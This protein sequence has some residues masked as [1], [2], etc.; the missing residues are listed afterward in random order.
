MDTM[1][2]DAGPTPERLHKAGQFFTVAGRARSSRKVTMLDDALGK[3]WLRQII[4]AQ[5][6]SALRRYALHWV[7]GGLQGPLGSVDLNRIYAFDPSS[8]TGLARSEAQLDHK[9]TYYAAKQAIGFNP[10]FVAD[11]VA[12]FGRGLQ[13]T[14]MSMGFRSP[15]RARERAAEYLS[16]AGAGLSK[17]FETLRG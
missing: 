12:C 13:E 11:Q 3:A 5:E 7:A 17:F 15:Y 6:Y 10:S 16:S 2:D 9:R 14:G 1:L 8:M 4:S